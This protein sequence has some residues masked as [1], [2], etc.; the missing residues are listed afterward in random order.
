[1]AKATPK[2]T[3]EQ[4]TIHPDD[5]LIQQYQAA[6]TAIDAFQ[7]RLNAITAA[8]MA[9]TSQPTPEALEDAKAR[10]N[11][12]LEG[13]YKSK[14]ALRGVKLDI[15][16][17]GYK[18]E[19][20]DIGDVSPEM[21]ELAQASLEGK[22]LVDGTESLY[23]SIVDYVCSARDEDGSPVLLEYQQNAINRIFFPA[24]VAATRTRTVKPKVEGAED[25]PSNTEKKIA[26]WPG[27]TVQANI[28][29]FK[30]KNQYM[31][32]GRGKNKLIADL[33]AV[34]MTVTGA[35]VDTWAAS[36]GPTLFS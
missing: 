4:V 1:M 33:A 16:L 8:I 19:Q 24:P 36:V 9:Q 27:T 13:E 14:S 7:A 15:D 20:A 18:F 12:F 10:I 29:H 31:V 22:I 11:A 5:M 3:P 35:Q 28:T 23:R 17:D 34:G 26:V 21:F 6:Q 32:W 30:D 25:L 2:T